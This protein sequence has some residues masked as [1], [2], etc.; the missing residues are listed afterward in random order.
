MDE[1]I[2]IIVPIYNAEKWLEKCVNSIIEQTYSNIEILLINDGSTDKSL[3]ICKKF[4]KID[5]RVKVLD[6]KNEG[7]SKT[8][9]LGIEKAIG[10]YIK[11]VDSDDWL[12]KKACKELIKIIE[13]EKTEL[14]ICGLNIYKN[15]ELLR[16]PHLEKK[17]VEIKKNIKEF[18]Y[19][20]KVFA[21]PCNKLYRKDKIA[22]NFRV[23]LDIGED[24]LFNIRY[25]ENI[26]KI[27][28]TDKC[29]Y[30]VCLDNDD[31]LNRKFRED[32]LDVN[33][34]LTDIE[35]QFCKKTYSNI[36]ERNFL[37]NKY[38]LL[39]H[40]HLLQIGRIYNKKE[41][42]NEIKKYSNDNRV[43]N[44]CKYAKMDRIDYKIFKNLVEN[45]HY[46]L[47]Y[48]FI[49]LKNVLIK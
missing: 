6:K 9:N 25:L 21:S 33:L 35:V 15:N 27:S 39:L 7:V 11:F 1:K 34:D 4:E 30:N 5:N 31:S 28:V 23:D 26:E 43:K 38:L 8:R 3:E 32:K 16:T 37:Y 49:K 46:T 20:Y 45:K 12:E 13:E 36:S 40:A 29:L 10:K 22:E 18:E 44:A 2:S 42:K 19:I 24:L 48:Y 41:M 17:I 14:V 47:I